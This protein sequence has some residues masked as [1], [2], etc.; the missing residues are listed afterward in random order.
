MFPPSRQ[1]LPARGPQKWT[2][3]KSLPEKLRN[4]SRNMASLICS[5]WVEHKLMSFQAPK[6]SEIS[7]DAKT[8]LNAVKILGT[9]LVTSSVFRLVLADTISI[10][11]DLIAHVASDVSNAALRVH[12]IAQNVE[13]RT[14]EADL[15]IGTDTGAGAKLKGKISELVDEGR[16]AASNTAQDVRESMGEKKE[17]W[18]KHGAETEEEV[19]RRLIA[20]IQGVCSLFRL[21]S[22]YLKHRI[23]RWLFERKKILRRGVPSSPS[24][25]SYAN[26]RTSLFL[27]L[28]RPPPES[29]ERSKK[30]SKGD[31]ARTRTS[32][33]PLV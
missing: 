33:N 5:P 2:K 31:L 1:S 10:G 25:K 11:Q 12:D 18:E 32:R 8:M 26:M 20:R 15:D 19:K 4:V 3:R 22:E 27:R 29:K 28:S 24:C 14:N 7:A 21:I 6:K 13:R 23:T 30:E 16:A 17:E 9:T